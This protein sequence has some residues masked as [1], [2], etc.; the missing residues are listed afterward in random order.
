MRHILQLMCVVMTTVVLLCA[1]QPKSTQQTDLHINSVTLGMNKADVLSGLSHD[2]KVTQ[3]PSGVDIWMV[4]EKHPLPDSSFYKIGFKDNKV[5]WIETDM[6][7]MFEGEGLKLARKLFT[8][9]S[10][11]TR[12]SKNPTQEESD[13]NLKRAT[14]PV[15]IWSLQGDDWSEQSLE[16]DFGEYVLVLHIGS[17]LDGKPYALLE[18]LE[19]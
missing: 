16:F 2:Y 13:R 14:V 9:F 5:A 17:T 3:V 19:H 8:D 7:P 1:Q 18:H 10:Y 4:I 6:Q 15:A 12:Q 11:H